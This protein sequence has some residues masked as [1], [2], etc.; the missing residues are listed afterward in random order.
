MHVYMISSKQFL[1]RHDYLQFLTAAVL[2]L[3]TCEVVVVEMMASWD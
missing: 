3:V 1:Q 2:L